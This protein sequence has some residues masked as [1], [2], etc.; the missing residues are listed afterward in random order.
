MYARVTLLWISLW[1]R[2]EGYT[3][4]PNGYVTYIE[5]ILWLFQYQWANPGEYG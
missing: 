2:L 1:F 4:I 3:Y 5:V